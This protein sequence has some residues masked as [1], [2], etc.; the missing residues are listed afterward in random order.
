MQHESEIAT[1]VSIERF[2]A[3]ALDYNVS[4][5]GAWM[6]LTEV[7]GQLSHWQPTVLRAVASAMTEAPPSRF[8]RR[9]NFAD[10]RV[11]LDWLANGKGTVLWRAR[12]SEAG[13]PV[14]VA[15][16]PALIAQAA[17]LTLN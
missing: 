17:A 4:E 5:Y 13:V 9:R 1:N 12:L 6:G 3:D 16:S 8:S 2:V 15:L 14:S 10:T 7:S 11:E